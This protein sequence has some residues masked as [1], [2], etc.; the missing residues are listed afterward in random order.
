MND[1]QILG[2]LVVAATTLGGFVAVIIKLTQPINELK[3][4]IQELKDCVKTLRDNNIIQDKRLDKHGKDIDELKQKVNEIE[5]KMNIY[6][7]E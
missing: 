1:I 3:L 7:K 4:V 5:T 2:Y 6:H